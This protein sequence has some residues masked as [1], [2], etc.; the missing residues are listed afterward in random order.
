MNRILLIAFMVVITIA[1]AVNADDYCSIPCW[2]GRHT[3][4]DF[5]VSVY[6]IERQEN[7]RYNITNNFYVSVL[8]SCT[9]MWRN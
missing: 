9:I 4:C 5:K 6:F 1:T 2:M 7:Q 3:M 8:R